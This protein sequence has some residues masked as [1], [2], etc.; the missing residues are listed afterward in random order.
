MRQMGKKYRCL[1]PTPSCLDKGALDQSQVKN[2]L[3][4]DGM[5]AVEE[6]APEA[7]KKNCERLLDIKTFTLNL[8]L[9]TVHLCIFT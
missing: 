6:T 7:S 5:H 4:A 8:I 9:C 1:T 2:S 3:A